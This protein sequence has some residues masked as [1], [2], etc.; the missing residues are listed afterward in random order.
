MFTRVFC[1][2]MQLIYTNGQ[3]KSQMWKNIK[4]RSSLKL[5][6]N[7]SQV[8]SVLQLSQ[9]ASFDVV[10]EIQVILLRNYDNQIYHLQLLPT[11]VGQWRTLHGR[12]ARDMPVWKLS[13][14]VPLV[15]RPVLPA[16]R[17]K[18]VQ[19]YWCQKIL[20]VPLPVSSYSFNRLGVWSCL[21]ALRCF[22]M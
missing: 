21:Q 14:A 13:D 16:R 15:G 6:F 4:V 22:I 17:N 20:V 11:Q 9:G 19:I 7:L 5:A 12:P 8:R 1:P 2:E 18:W 3:G 10:S